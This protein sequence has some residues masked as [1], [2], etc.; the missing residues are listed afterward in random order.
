MSARWQQKLD[1]SDVFRADMPF[2]Q[3]RDFMV[4]RVRMLALFDMELQEIADWL[5]EST[6][7]D[8]WDVS[9]DASYDWADANRVWVV[10]R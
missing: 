5:A 8:E 10:T 1:V 4:D 9:W 6:T 2:E 7:V 3:R